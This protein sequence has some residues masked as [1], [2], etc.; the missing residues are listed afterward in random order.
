MPPRITQDPALTLCPDFGT[1]LFAAFRNSHIIASNGTLS[2]A[3]VTQQ[4]TEAWTQDNAAQQVLF[5]QQQQHDQLAQE[6]AALAAQEALDQ[7]REEQACQDNADR[8]ELEKKKPKMKNF[9]ATMTVSDYIAPRPSAYA[10]HKLEKFAYIKL[11]YFT[12][13]GR[14]DASSTRTT[15][16]GE[17][18]AF[19]RGEA[20]LSPYAQSK[21]SQPLSMSSPTMH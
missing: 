2:H 19:A 1:D 13:E 11:W 17:T 8:L 12:P 21:Q 15:A 4:L 20:T 7:Q 9:D 16:S 5:A 6:A 18:L 10:I 3:E 14:H